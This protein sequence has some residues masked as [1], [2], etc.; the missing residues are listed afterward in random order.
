M[1]AQDNPIQS[2][3]SAFDALARRDWTTLARRTDPQA[4]IDL[5]QKSLGLIVLMAEQVKAG[6]R[7]EGG[8]NPDDVV[9]AEHLGKVGGERALGFRDHATISELASLSTEAFFIRWCQA[10]YG[11]TTQANPVDEVVDLYRRI[12]GEVNEKN[13]VAHVLYRRESRH[14]EADELKI[15]LPGRVLIMPMRNVAGRWL[16]TLNDDLGWSIS[17]G[18]TLR[19]WIPRG[20]IAHPRRDLPESP[21]SPIPE[22]VNAPPGA[23]RIV[24]E[25][26]A[27]FERGDW[28]NL[29]LLVH[30]ERLASFQREEI[31]YLAAWSESRETRARA[32]REGASV[33]MLSYDDSLSSEG[34]ARVADV[35]IA[36]FGRRTIGALA[37]L[38]PQ[39]FFEAWCA[40]AYALPSL[41][42]AKRQLKR[43]IIGHVFEGD[44][45]AH[46]LYRSGRLYAPERM[47]LK[48]SSQGWRLLLNDDVGSIA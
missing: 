12:I 46:V 35:E 27:A 8:Y 38:S 20:Q 41:G 3:H 29:A 2:L 11:D 37:A 6:Q 19:P 5:R 26:V 45:L 39:A 36:V 13:G 43:E 28:T 21:P 9:I 16:M 47:P 30:P 4:L 10:V 33:F 23:D 18:R 24:Q 1:H 34:M 15:D 42:L 40:A 32:Q 44:S 25:A 22:R 7:P 14:I 17:F 31:A 48:W